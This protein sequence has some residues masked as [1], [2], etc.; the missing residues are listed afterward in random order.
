MDKPS[1]K[2][3]GHRGRTKR[4]RSE[5]QKKGIGNKILLGYSSKADTRDLK[6]T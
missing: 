1:A 6:T 3:Y 5:R 2:K 4:G